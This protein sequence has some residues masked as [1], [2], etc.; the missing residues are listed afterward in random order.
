MK[1][2]QF[3]TIVGFAGTGIL[4]TSCSMDNPIHAY[5]V[6][7]KMPNSSVA[8]NSLQSG[9][10]APTSG[11]LYRCFALNI[12]GSGISPDPR[13][14]CT[15]GSMGQMVGLAGIAGG[16]VSGDVLAGPSRK[17]QLIGVEV[18][19]ASTIQGCP[20]FDDIFGAAA[21]PNHALNGVNAYDLGESTIDVFGDSVV[22][23][24]A[25]FSSPPQLFQHCDSTNGS[26]S[27][28]SG[29]QLSFMPGYS[30]LP[31]APT[32]L[33]GTASPGTFH[34]SGGVPPYTYAYTTSPSISG[35]T[36]L[37]STDTTSASFTPPYVAGS[38]PQFK[39]VVTDTHLAQATQTVSISGN[40]TSLRLMGPFAAQA[41]SCVPFQLISSDSNGNP[42]IAASNLSS[43]GISDGSAGGSFYSDASCGSLIA[44]S[45]Y[46]PNISAGGVIGSFGTL[47]ILYYKNP[48]VQ[49]VTF[50][51]PL[52]MGGTFVLS[53]TPA[54]YIFQSY[55][56][57]NTAPTSIAQGQ[58][59]ATAIQALLETSAGTLTSPQNT[60][61]ANARTLT[62]SG[63]DPSDYFYY[64][65]NCLNAAANINLNPFQASSGAYYLKTQTPLSSA[66]W[67]VTDQYGVSGSIILAVV[68]PTPTPVPTPIAQVVSLAYYDATHADITFSEAMNSLATA[69]ANYTWASANT[70]FPV[71]GLSISQLSG[72]LYRLSYTSGRVC[73]GDTVTVT[74][75]GDSGGNMIPATNNSATIGAFSATAPYVP[76]SVN[77]SSGTGTT[78]PTFSLTSSFFSP[79]DRVAFYSNATCTTPS[80]LAITSAYAT[81]GGN[82]LLSATT[83]ALAPGIYPLYL[84]TVSA[85]ENKST[86]SPVFNVTW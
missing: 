51:V 77:V 4:A 52:N 61:D 30:N 17:I 53:G 47:S 64:D 10:V 63:S 22:S 31:A 48:T 18:T 8:Q 15:D 83:G 33:Y 36:L 38:S 71:T 21:D 7:V 16:T 58:C 72:P 27:G 60:S 26:G 80:P 79:G 41:G 84:Q 25:N 55:T 70:V 68:A 44:T 50:S 78:H 40:G 82:T 5:Q 11:I 14:G 23:I 76:L 43:S 9:Y 19:A 49:A 6:A 39:M 13:F 1:Y 74:K 59:S 75:V 62:V 54:K 35:G 29:L 67:Q 20:S 57:A 66:T 86:C 12:L 45:S 28:N 3:I 69:A 46:P 85:C 65:S 37:V 2:R 42:A 34:A 81:V 24:T 56:T 32:I 73:L